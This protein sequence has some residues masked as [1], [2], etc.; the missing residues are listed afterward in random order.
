[1]SSPDNSHVKEY[2]LWS[3]PNGWCFYYACKLV[4][5]MLNQVRVQERGPREV[6]MHNPAL[7]DP[8]QP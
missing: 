6:A 4:D 2:Y 3:M 1:M 5:A 8:L 7:I